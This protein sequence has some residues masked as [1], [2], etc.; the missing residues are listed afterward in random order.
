MVAHNDRDHPHLHL[1]VNIVNPETGRANRVS[2]SKKKLSTWAE[3]YEREHGK[4]YCKKRVENNAKRAQD[5]KVKYE[6]PELDLKSNITKLF[7]AA[8]SGQA[9]R[10]ALAEHGLTLAQGKRIVVIDR[11][12][13]FTA[14]P[15]KSKA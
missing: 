5:Q 10:A 4:I 8:D 3:S 15:A 9:F 14:S 13:R 7:H 12:E 1:I 2:F 11:E 6:E